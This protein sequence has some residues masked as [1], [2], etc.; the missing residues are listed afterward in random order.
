VHMSAFDPGPKQTWT[1]ALHMPAFGGKADILFALQMSALIQSERAAIIL[2]A[3]GVT[4][5]R[6]VA[7]PIASSL[8]TSGTGARAK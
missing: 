1:I 5:N 2:H 6:F 4:L 7:R 3:E 8:V